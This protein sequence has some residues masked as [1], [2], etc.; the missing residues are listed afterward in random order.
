MN[1][2]P[3]VTIVTPTF[4]LLKGGRE[5]SF[6]QCVESVHA[7]SYGAI[8]HLVMDGGS[9]DGTHELIAEYEAR[10]WLRCISEP[11]EG[12]YDAMNKGLQASTGKYIAFLNSDDFWHDSHAVEESVRILES[13]GAA[14]SYAPNNII[15]EAGKRLHVQEPELGS[16]VTEMPFCHQTMFTRTDV[17]R[18]LGGFDCKHYRIIADNDLITR[19]LLRGHKAAY[20]PLNFTS[21]R[22]G[23]VSAC[24]EGDGRYEEVAALYRQHYLPL[25]GTSGNEPLNKYNMPDT[26]LPAL[27]AQLHPSVFAQVCRYV[28]P[29]SRT[30]PVSLVPTS[31]V[32]S[33]WHGPL[34]LPLL[35]SRVEA[36]GTHTRWLLLGFLP[37]LSRTMHRSSFVIRTT[38]RLLGIP[39]WRIKTNP[40]LGYKHALFGFIPM[41]GVRR[42]HE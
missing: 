31:T 34:R 27:A 22:L 29:L 3:A 15:N 28:L 12:I 39:I 6:R 25:V 40:G 16:F 36:G 4:N 20:V 26:L 21:Y 42:T 17:M 7:Q 9:T 10:G 19:I 18:E 24:T 11:D 35:T 41:G 2:P 8:E 38:Y 32:I 37:F 33:R 14:F 30:A 5:G 1:P 13:T 23:G